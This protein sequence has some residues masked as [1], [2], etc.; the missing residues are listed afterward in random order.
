MLD[1]TIARTGR[2]LEGG[3]R[4][5]VMLGQTINQGM[6][7]NALQAA[8][9]RINAGE[10]AN[11]VIQQL[12]AQDPAAAQQLMNLKQGNMALQQQ[13][14]EMDVLKQK[15]GMQSLQQAAMPLLG[16]IM[17]DNPAVQDK[18]IDE[19]SNIFK[20]QSDGI[21]ESLQGIKSL[22]GPEKINALSGLVKTLRSAGI[23]PD[24]PSQLQGG[25]ALGQNLSL[26]DQAL[27]AGDT[28][29]AELIKR[30]IDPYSGSFAR[31]A[32]AGEARL[33]TEQGL[34]PVLAQREAGKIQ[35]T[36]QTA[37]GQAQLTQEQQA[38]A[39]GQREMND[40]AR[41]KENSVAAINQQL[42]QINTLRSHPGFEGAVGTSSI[43][44]SIPGGKS[45]GFERQ[46]EKLDAQSFMAMIPN[47][48]GMGAL[49]NAEG[50]KVS[51]ALSAL[52]A[53]LSEE[54]FKK[55]LQTIEQTLMQA[56]ER[57]K[58]GNFIKQDAQQAQPA[59]VG[60]FKI[61]VE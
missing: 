35:A 15:Y 9:A 22:Q 42:Q 39:K 5:G 14:Q 2:S 16:S 60:R 53:G 37:T 31:G 4:G 59:S 25:T 7:K 11:A 17:Q 26:Y 41:S 52:N 24:D 30:N 27:A 46:L 19:A 12:M 48:A 8:Q 18:L 57:I 55:E 21:F 44:P 49:S 29:R 1:S 38:V 20:G 50:Q 33:M 10:D 13:Q 61:E 58:T 56:R 40:A 6:S 34:N 43:L 54:E 45:Y 3:L 28:E 32:G 23:F 36:E 51:A 47:L